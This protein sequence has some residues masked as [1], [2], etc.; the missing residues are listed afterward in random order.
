MKNFCIIVAIIGMT[1]LCFADTTIVQKV[2]SGPMMGQPGTNAIQTMKIKGTKARID[3][4][5]VKQY[6][7]LDLTSKKVYLIDTEKKQQS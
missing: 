7:V 5:N 3:H 6:Q 4:D 1:S 2:E